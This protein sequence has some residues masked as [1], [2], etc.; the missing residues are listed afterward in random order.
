MKDLKFA[1][2]SEKPTPFSGPA[3]M[4]WG[5]NSFKKEN[6]E[7][8]VKDCGIFVKKKLAKFSWARHTSLQYS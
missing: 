1:L 8:F 7:I 2:W 4:L 3:A 5:P 6:C